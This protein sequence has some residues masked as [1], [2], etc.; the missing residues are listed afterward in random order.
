MTNHIVLFR[1]R[2]DVS[3]ELRAAVSETFKKEIEALPS[4][5]PFIREVKVGFNT[6]EAESW[7]ICLLS[8]FDS[9]SQAKAYGAHPSHRAA[10]AKLMA[11]IAQRACVDFED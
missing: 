4:Q 7:D 11:H 8:R 2:D 6:N 9:L 3:L 1:F 5:L 10:A